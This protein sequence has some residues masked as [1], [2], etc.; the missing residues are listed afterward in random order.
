M[1]LR[2]LALAAT[3]PDYDR[4]ACRWLARWLSERDPSI[5]QVAEVAATLADLPSEPAG[6]DAV[7]GMLA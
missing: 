6:L 5:E 3:R 7:L 1:A 2:M 4:W